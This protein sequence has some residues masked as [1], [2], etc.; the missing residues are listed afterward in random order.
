MS[1]KH[2]QEPAKLQGGSYTPSI[3]ETH[4]S[5]KAIGATLI[6]EV[7]TEEVIERRLI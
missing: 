5:K 1:Q 7:K 4:A 2:A 3:V 6:Q